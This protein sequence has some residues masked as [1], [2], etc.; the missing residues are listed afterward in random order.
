MRRWRKKEGSFD[1]EMEQQ[2]EA[3]VQLDHVS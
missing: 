3:G 1:G 2:D